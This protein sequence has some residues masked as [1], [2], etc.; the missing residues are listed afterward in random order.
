[1]SAS[2]EEE[3]WNIFTYYTM[4]SNPRDPSKLNSIG[5]AKFCRDIMV[6]DQSMTEKPILAADVHLLFTSEIKKNQMIV[7]ITCNYY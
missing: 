6:L 5:L 1:M 2:I 7:S 4:H 3:L